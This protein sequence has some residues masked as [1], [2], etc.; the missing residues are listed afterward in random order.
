MWGGSAPQARRAWGGG[1]WGSGKGE[2]KKKR[3][4]REEEGKRERGKN[5]PPQAA[6]RSSW[7][8]PPQ[9]ARRSCVTSIYALALQERGCHHAALC[10]P[11]L[12]LGGRD[13]RTSR[14]SSCCGYCCC[15]SCCCCFHLFQSFCFLLKSA[16]KPG[17]CC[18]AA[19][20]LALGQTPFVS[21]W[22]VCTL[23]Q[24][25]SSFAAR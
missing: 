11:Q 6:R 4:G 3:R 13:G 21:G 19:H 5:V 20:A 14:S 9:A 15:C 7:Y 22:L 2:E 12:L 23:G 10:S 1:R 17:F 8:G 24:T 18:C 25:P 16:A